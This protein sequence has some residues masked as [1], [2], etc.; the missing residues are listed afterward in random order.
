M[1]NL[2]SEDKRRSATGIF[3]VFTIPPV[4]DGAIDTSI[5][6]M[7]VTY[8]YGGFSP[9]VAVTPLIDG[10]ATITIAVQYENIMI[11]SDKDNTTPKWDIL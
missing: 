5:E 10:V 3:S 6:R 2:D 8:I 4:P 1:A 11:G 9:G 7:H